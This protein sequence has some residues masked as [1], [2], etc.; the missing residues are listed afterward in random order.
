[1]LQEPA[2]RVNECSQVAFRISPARLVFFDLPYRKSASDS[3]HRR[4]QRLKLSATA[5]GVGEG[6]EGP[7]IPVPSEIDS[8]V[9]MKGLDISV[10]RS[11]AGGRHIEYEGEDTA[12]KSR[13][14]AAP[15]QHQWLA[16][17]LA[18]QLP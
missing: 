12:A 17:P 9:S 1:M 10:R 7:S 2:H 3:H 15:S 4:F 14:Q 11:I 6:M 5:N 18:R 13:G 16:F 8:A